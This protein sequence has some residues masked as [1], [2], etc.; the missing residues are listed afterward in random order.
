M[1]EKN[2]KHVCLINAYDLQTLSKSALHAYIKMLTNKPEFIIAEMQTL[3]GNSASVNYAILHEL[4][5]AKL[6][7]HTHSAPGRQSAYSL[8]NHLVDFQRVSLTTTDCCDLNKNAVNDGAEKVSE[9][10]CPEDTKRLAAKFRLPVDFLEAKLVEREQRTGRPRDY[11]YAEMVLTH[12]KHFANK[13]FEGLF[14][15]LFIRIPYFQPSLSF[16][17]ASSPQDERQ[18]PVNAD[19]VSQGQPARQTATDF[20]K[21]VI[22]SEGGKVFAS[23]FGEKQVLRLNN[24]QKELLS[25]VTDAELAR[26]SIQ[27]LLGRGVKNVENNVILI[28]NRME[29]LRNAPTVMRTSAF[30]PPKAAMRSASLDF[31]AQERQKAASEIID[32]HSFTVNSLGA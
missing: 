18:T 10:A 7:E 27:N 15:Y 25:A 13:S 30:L 32:V 31:L 26:K 1:N 24:Y 21:A 11:H 9:N 2:E 28:M 8:K 4:T 16:F 6:V 17:A 22:A 29:E 3:T 12:A 19:R 14:Y 20:D 23:F 5:V